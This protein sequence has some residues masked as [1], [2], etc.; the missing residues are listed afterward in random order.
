MKQTKIQTNPCPKITGALFYLRCWRTL[1]RGESVDFE[2]HYRRPPPS[3]P[4]RRQS[5]LHRVYLY[6]CRGVARFAS[7]RI[8]QPHPL[9]GTPTKKKT[10]GFDGCWLLH[11]W[12]NERNASRS[13][14][15]LHTLDGVRR[16]YVR[17]VYIYMCWGAST[18]IQPSSQPARSAYH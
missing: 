16:Y 4:T 8:A 11:R 18:V 1:K 12:V 9:L 7:A 5:P 17:C 6:M 13:C 15:D 3:P 10:P 14:G 2:S